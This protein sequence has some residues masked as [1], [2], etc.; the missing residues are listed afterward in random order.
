MS[1]SKANCD[2]SDV[3]FVKVRKKPLIIDKWLFE[4]GKEID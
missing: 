1:N 3:G 2:S 4:G